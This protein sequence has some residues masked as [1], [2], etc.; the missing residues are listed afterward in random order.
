MEKKTFIALCACV[1][2]GISLF[3]QENFKAM[4]F[5]TLDQ[6]VQT[7]SINPTEKFSI[8]ISNL[9]IGYYYI[10]MPSMNVEPI[11][12]IKIN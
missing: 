7:I 8:N 3:I 6:I 2:S 5:N 12:Y 9:T 10:T 11:K 4:F 1:V